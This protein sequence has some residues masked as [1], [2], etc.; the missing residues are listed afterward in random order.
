MRYFKLPLKDGQDEYYAVSGDSEPFWWYS[1]TCR[2]WK[3]TT[4]GDPWAGWF[5]KASH[6][7]RSDNIVEVSKLEVLVVVGNVKE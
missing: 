6:G 7:H 2:Y 1:Y 3:Q 4:K 5:S